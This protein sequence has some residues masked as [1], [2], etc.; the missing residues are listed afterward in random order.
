MAIR[1]VLLP[2]FDREMANTPKTLERVPEQKL[3]WKPHEKSISMGR[4]A[5]HLSNIPTDVVTTIEK[6][7]RGCSTGR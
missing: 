5:F 2:E 6:E 3:G 1:D 7:S 4:F